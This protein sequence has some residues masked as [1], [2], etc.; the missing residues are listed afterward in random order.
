MNLL[1]AVISDSFSDNT[2]NKHI[3]KNKEKLIE[4]KDRQSSSEDTDGYTT[5]SSPCSFNNNT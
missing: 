3:D 1:L 4:G 5:P 2:K